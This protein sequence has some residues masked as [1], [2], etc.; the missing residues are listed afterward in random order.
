MKP[1]IDPP[2]LKQL[3]THL[4]ICWRLSWGALPRQSDC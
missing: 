2:L 3:D 1:I 4:A